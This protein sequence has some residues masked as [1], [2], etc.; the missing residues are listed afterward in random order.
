MVSSY[1]PTGRPTYPNYQEVV[2]AY[3]ALRAQYDQL[4]VREQQQAQRIAQLERALL[5]ANQGRASAAGQSPATD[6]QIAELVAHLEREQATVASLRAVAERA[7]QQAATVEQEYRAALERARLIEEKLA[8]AE[9]KLAT[10][11]SQQDDSGD[12]AEWRERYLRQQADAE[13]FRRRQE[14][15]FAQQATEERRDL[16]RDMLPLADHLELGLQHQAQD[17]AGDDPR[18]QSYAGNLR[19]VRQAFLDTLE[20]YGVRLL[21]ALGEP[22]D[23]NL[24]E[25]LGHLPSNDVPEEYVAHVVQNGYTDPDGLVRPAR[26][27]VSSGP[28]TAVAD[29]S[30]KVQER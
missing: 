13:N 16:L 30:Q 29:I 20:R 25:A 4:A 5:Q 7:E 23:P 10:L 6:H 11:Q 3:R 27:L 14:R 19:A 8:A 22:F 26:V 1:R 28:P 21:P 2:Q 15:R 17:A 9:E 18:L 12:A 24:H